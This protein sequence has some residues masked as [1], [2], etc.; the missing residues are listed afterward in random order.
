KA[1]HQE[2]KCIQEPIFVIVDDTVCEKTKPSS[3]AMITI[4]N[5]YDVVQ[6]VPEDPLNPTGTVD[7]RS[8]LLKVFKLI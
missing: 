5:I 2:A 7:V 1:I 8:G 4:L 6:F 3:Q